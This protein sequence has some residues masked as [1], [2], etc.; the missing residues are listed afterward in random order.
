VDH[1][2]SVDATRRLGRLGTLEGAAQP[3]T[4]RAVSGGTPVTDETD[5][6]E[7]PPISVIVPFS[8]PQDEADE[9]C[10]SLLALALRDGDEILLVDNSP[11]TI[12][13][14]APPARRI[15]A[16]EERSSYYARNAGAAAAANDWLLFMD[17]DCRPLAPDMLDRFFAPAPPERCGALAGGVV[18]SPGSDTLLARHAQSRH[19]LDQKVALGQ[20]RP[21]ALTANLLVRRSAWQSVGGFCETVRSGG[22]RD[23]SWRLGAAGWS[24]ELRDDAAVA[25]LHQEHWRPAMRKFVRYGAGA[26]WLARRHPSASSMRPP[27]GRGVGRA[28]VGTAV[29]LAT[30]RPE[31]AA[32]KAI[33]GAA[34]V[35]LNLGYLLENRPPPAAA[36]TNGRAAG[37]VV[38]ADEA[39][40]SAAGDLSAAARV[41]ALRRPS[42]PHAE[43]LRGVPVVFAEDDGNGRRLL[44]LAYLAL[45]RPTAVG[46]EALRD[47]RGARPALHEV[48]SI[49]RRLLDDDAAAQPVARG[50]EARAVLE[51]VTALIGT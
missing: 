37:P 18:D 47:A 34:I 43:Q 38:I 10:A 28:V 9:V 12:A 42:A 51:R 39:P 5:R 33:D 48:A 23:F 3:R 1:A 32:F 21:F 49:A 7:R 19:Y 8:G 44:D 36:A 4:I 30:R 35:A 40:G 41:E 13:D 14:P 24:I 2:R 46:A 27:L 11:H 50:P 45:R 25:H 15:R 22:D 6:Q 26:A 29:W 31:R 17:A 20:D 16:I